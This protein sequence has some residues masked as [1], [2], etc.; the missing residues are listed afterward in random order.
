MAPPGFP[1]ATLTAIEDLW[2]PF[3]AGALLA[4]VGHLLRILSQM[5]EEVGYIA[6]T[7]ARTHRQE[8]PEEGDEQA[9]MQGRIE[10]S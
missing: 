7:K 9:L 1:P 5:M 8:A 3:G 4:R 2:S 10:R 6:E